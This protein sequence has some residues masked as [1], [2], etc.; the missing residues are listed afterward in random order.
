LINIFCH[1]IA[2]LGA[3]R[4]PDCSKWQR[5]GP[6][7]CPSVITVYFNL[8]CRTETLRGTHLCHVMSET[9]CEDRGASQSGLQVSRPRESL[10]L[11]RHSSNI[12]YIL[13][14]RHIVLM[15]TM[16]D[17]ASTKILD[18]LKRIVMRISE[19]L[20]RWLLLRSYWTM[21][22]ADECF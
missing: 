15:A 4:D 17:S 18:S 7:N 13:G 1:S 3:A 6:R 10:Q 2:S 22:K 9:S 11:Q 8:L 14:L 20:Q 21:A 5:I 16:C 12:F 19:E